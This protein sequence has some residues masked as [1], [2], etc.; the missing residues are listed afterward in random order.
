MKV[1]EPQKLPSGKW[2]IRLRLGG[3]SYPITC[4]TAK[5]C[6]RQAEAIKSDYQIG[7]E[8]QAFQT[9]GTLGAMC[10]DYIAK[11]KSMRSPSTLRGYQKIRDTH[12]QDV[13]SKPP[14]KIDWQKAVTED[15]KT[16]APKSV[17]NAWSFVCSVLKENGY[18]KPRVILPASVSNTRAWLDAEQIPVFIDAIRGDVCE[19]AALLGLHSLRMSELLGLTWGNVDL[20]NNILHIRGAVVIGE[21]DKPVQKTTNKNLTSRRDVPIMIPRLYELLEKG[22][23]DADPDARV[24]PYRDCT[25]YNH[26]TSA[27]ERA[28]L[29]KVSPHG[30]RHSFA[31]LALHIGMSE[32]ECMEIGGWSNPATMHRIYTH[33]SAADRLKAENKMAQFYKGKI[34]TFS[35]TSK[36]G[37]IQKR[38]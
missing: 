28:G 26:V 11:R 3:E 5:E 13:M 23:E 15:S 16:Y 8:I 14:R 10:D 24:V 31:S 30:L 38:Q 21:D 37:E 17:A 1:P 22:A 2:F 27:C 34:A 18:L 12:F 36:N 6:K 32:R 19:I 4:R 35:E 33:L 25:V 7:K 9:H 29:P 20:E